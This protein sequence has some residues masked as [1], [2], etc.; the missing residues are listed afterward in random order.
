MSSRELLKAIGEIDERFIDEAAE[1][2]S[3]AKPAARRVSRR[4]WVAAAA[5]FIVA[6]GVGITVI[7]GTF[8]S[9]NKASSND[10]QYSMNSSQNYGIRNTAPASPDGVMEDTVPSLIEDAVPSI[11]QASAETA[12]NSQFDL[13][14]KAAGRYSMISKAVEDDHLHPGSIIQRDAAKALW[15]L[16]VIGR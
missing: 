11:A 16:T 10:M 15:H 7:P 9:A 13:H 5:C 8:R 3:A 12:G 14:L 4:G 6:C 1:S 2:Y